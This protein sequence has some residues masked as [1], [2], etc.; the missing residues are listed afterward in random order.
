MPPSPSPM[1]ALKGRWDKPLLA[2]GGQGQVTLEGCATFRELVLKAMREIRAALPQEEPDRARDPRP[3]RERCRRLWQER[4]QGLFDQLLRRLAEHGLEAGPELPVGR[5]QTRDAVD[6]RGADCRGGSFRGAPLENIHFQHADLRGVS[7]EGAR[8]IETGFELAL[9][10]GATFAYAECQFADFRSSCCDRASFLHADCS[11]ARFDGAR[12]RQAEFSGATCFAA[13]FKGAFLHKAA[14]SAMKI[15]HYTAFGKPGEQSEAERS[16]PPKV[17]DRSEEDWFIAHLNPHWLRA[18]EVNAAIRG[19]LKASGDF[20]A[21]DQYQY[22]ELV[23]RR[24]LIVGQ[25]V[26]YFFEWF[27]KDRIFGYGLKWHRPLVTI[28]LM[29]SVWTAGFT[30]YFHVTGGQP[31]VHS[32][33]DGLYY[34]I[35]CLTTLGLGNLSDVVGF[36]GK[37]LVCSEALIGSVLMPVFLLAYARK[38]LQ[39]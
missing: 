23:C 6:L 39:D 35:V 3:W 20:L 31:L 8:C 19:L 7:F 13:S 30:T 2:P 37:F 9:C 32:F 15:N 25:P 1:A 10:D 29:V 17:Q 21:A 36:W 14:I 11:M 4:A 33:G 27:F 26:V 16:K 5:Y 22:H 24:H 12:L 28:F 38:I 34:S 18:T